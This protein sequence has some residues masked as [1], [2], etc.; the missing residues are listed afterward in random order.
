MKKLEP[1]GFLTFI[2]VVLL[3]L[4]VL[5]S[6]AHAQSPLDKKLSIS[7][8][9]EQLKKAL[10]KI[11]SI[12]GTKFTFNEQIA[13]SSIKISVTARDKS[14]KEILTLAFADKPL[15]FSILDKEVFIRLDPEKTKKDE[16][17]P[18]ANPAHQRKVYTK[19]NS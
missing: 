6:R 10:D 15:Q 5:Q 13:S 7:L 2:A 4:I 9:N 18:A 1:V 19:R 12:S 11:T 8:K 17:G 3:F 16:A 14:L